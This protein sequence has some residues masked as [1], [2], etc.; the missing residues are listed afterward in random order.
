LTDRDHA[1]AIF[2]TVDPH[3]RR[4]VD[5]EMQRA[6]CACVGAPTPDATLC[7]KMDSCA[8]PL[9]AETCMRVS[10]PDRDASRV[11]SDDR[12][13]SFKILAFTRL[14]LPKQIFIFLPIF[15]WR[16]MTFPVQTLKLCRAEMVRRPV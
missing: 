5:R 14:K 13:L 7:S 2:E 1:P 8:A 10:T 3:Q 11:Y 16:S 12:W 15:R 4:W 6:L 9:L